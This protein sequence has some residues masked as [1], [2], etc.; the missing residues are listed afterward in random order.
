MEREQLIELCQVTMENFRECIG[1]TVA[2]GLYHSLGSRKTGEIEGGEV[3]VILEL[4]E[5]SR[6]ELCGVV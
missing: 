1:L 5:N 2:E 3:V 6:E 4:S